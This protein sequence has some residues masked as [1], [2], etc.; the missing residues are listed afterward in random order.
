MIFFCDEKF[1]QSSHNLTLQ[2]IANVGN[3]IKDEQTLSTQLLLWRS[4]EVKPPQNFHNLLLCT[5]EV[6]H[7]PLLFRCCK[8]VEERPFV[9]LHTK[10]EG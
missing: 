3:I 9:A 8:K 4:E 1:S 7:Q 2:P 10:V 6:V 5:E